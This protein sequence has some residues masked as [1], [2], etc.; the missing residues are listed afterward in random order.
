MD[1]ETIDRILPD[2]WELQGCSRLGVS[3]KHGE[4]VVF[5]FREDQDVMIQAYDIDGPKRHTF[6]TLREVDQLPKV[7]AALHVA[8]HGMTPEPEVTA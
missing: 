8:L 2:G 4:N 5:L 6:L 1:R 7:V 3:A